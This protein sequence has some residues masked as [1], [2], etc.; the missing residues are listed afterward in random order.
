MSAADVVYAVTALLES[1]GDGPDDVPLSFWKAYDALSKCVL[2]LFFV[3]VLFVFVC[4]WLVLCLLG[5]VF[6][7]C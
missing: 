4:V 6:S 1:V 2:F 3:Q 7:L 5:P